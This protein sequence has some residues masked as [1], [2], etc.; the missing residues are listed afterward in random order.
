M[1]AFICTDKHFSVIAYYVGN[2]T[3]IDPQVIA[4]KLKSI[5]IDSVN[6]RYKEKT[7]KTKCKL[8]HTGD[9]YSVFDIIRLI[10]CWQ[11]QSCENQ[12]SLDYWMMCQWL[13]SLFTDNQV[14]LASSQSDKWSI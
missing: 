1:S 10:E 8:M 6:Y 11:Y 5:N 7:R 4:D 12:Y 2:I 9:N 13:I 3:D 14:E